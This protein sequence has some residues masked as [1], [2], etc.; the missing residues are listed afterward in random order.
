MTCVC[1]ETSTIAC[2]LQKAAA[3]QKDRNFIRTQPR[4]SQLVLFWYPLSYKRQ[5]AQVGDIVTPLQ[6]PACMGADG[7]VSGG[8]T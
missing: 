8:V 3:Y 6:T 1:T 2:M 7:C 4:T 5:R